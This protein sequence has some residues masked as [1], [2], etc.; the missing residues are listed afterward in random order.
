MTSDAPER[1]DAPKIARVATFFAAYPDSIDLPDGAYFCAAWRSPV[2]GFTDRVALHLQDGKA[3]VWL[4]PR[5][6]GSLV[7]SVRF[8]RLRRERGKFASY[9][10][11]VMPVVR[12]LGGPSFPRLSVDS[13]ATFAEDEFD[14]NEGENES[15]NTVVEMT[16]Q[17]VF[18]KG[19][20]WEACAPDQDIMGPTLTR[21]IDAMILVVNAYRFAQRV[22]I[23]APARERLGPVIIAATRPADPEDGDWDEE[24]HDV[25]NAFAGYLGST[26]STV[27]PGDPMLRMRKLIELQQ[28]DHPMIPLAELQHDLTNAFHLDGNFRATVIFAHS[29]SEVLIDTAML[30]MLHEEGKSPAEAARVFDQPL[31]SRLL[32]E[33]HERLGG[34][35]NDQGSAPVAR[36]LRDL[37]YVRHRV[38]HAGYG[39]THDEA[40]LAREAHFDLG[41]HL[42]DRLALRAKKYPLT[43][44]MVVTAGGFE[45]RGVRTKAAAEAIRLAE[46]EALQDFLT[47]RAEVLRLRG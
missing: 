47:W 16:A 35:W 42:R 27:G 23:P 45:R 10:A 44:G 41:V 6:A 28:I 25:F 30:G 9:Y 46:S 12:K 40:K 17:I 7:A 2:R 14:D 32:R 5:L 21:C 15:W 36:W 1:Q 13:S 43:A 29:A 39:P 38:A 31:K 24:V 37:L 22:V 34:A 19:G 4:D 18:P 33:F 11:S 20:F 26:L 8:H 3:H